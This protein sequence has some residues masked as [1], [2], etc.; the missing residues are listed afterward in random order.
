[1][2]QDKDNRTGKKD[3]EPLKNEKKGYVYV[4][5]TADLKVKAWGN[6]LEK[7]FENAALGGMD[8]ITDTSKVERKLKK[9][10]TISSKRPESLLYDFLE[11]LLFLIDTEGFIFA[12]AKE[13]R[14]AKNQDGDY[15][16]WCTALG[17]SYKGY[18][19]KGD[20]KAVTYSDMEISEKDG[21]FE[22]I[23]LY[24]I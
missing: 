16:V 20:I 13:M 5:H 9:K 21:G 15:E 4:D 11:E 2:A 17:D 23:V 24:D 14:I 7:A 6:T 12:E 10:I 19:R 18:E 3:K 22:I 1:M 8:F